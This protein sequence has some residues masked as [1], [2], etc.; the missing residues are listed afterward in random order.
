MNLNLNL[1]CQACQTWQ[2]VSMSLPNDCKLN[3]VICSK[4]GRNLISEPK[5]TDSLGKQPRHIKIIKNPS[6]NY[7]G[8]RPGAGRRP[9][10]YGRY[11]KPQR[12]PVS[13]RIS[14]ETAALIKGKK[15]L[16]PVIIKHQDIDYP[17]KQDIIAGG[18]KQICIRL[19]ND[20][21][22]ILQTKHNK[23]SFLESVIKAEYC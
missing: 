5:L 23:S 20:A 2:N 4:C 14:H 1:Y 8:P 10:K 16:S 22:S 3:D 12:K 19:N 17:D 11:N 7:G 6:P 15:D 18:R 13:F 21:V 9:G